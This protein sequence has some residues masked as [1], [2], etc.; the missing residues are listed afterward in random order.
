MYSGNSYPSVLTDHLLCVVF[1]L[2]T[3]IEK[4]DQQ[5]ALGET[6]CTTMSNDGT[7]ACAFLC[8][9]IAERLLQSNGKPLTWQEVAK[10]SEEIISQSPSSFNHLRDKGRL[11]DAQEATSL[12]WRGGVLSHHELTEEIISSDGVFTEKGK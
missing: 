1:Y 4:A 9:V 12:L 10:F 7:N 3:V 11:Y 5:I 6:I 2:G 8:A